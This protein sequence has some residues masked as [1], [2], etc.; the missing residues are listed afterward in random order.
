[1][2]IDDDPN[3]LYEY[4][5]LKDASSTIRL[6]HIQAQHI[7][8]G[9]LPGVPRCSLRQC[10]LANKPKYTAL[11]YA[12]GDANDTKP[13][14]LDGRRKEVT[15]SLWQ[16]L[17]Q[18]ARD[19]RDE[20]IEIQAYWIDAL[21][22]NQEDDVE[23]SDQVAM[24]GQIYKKASKLVVWLGA[25][26]HDSHHAFDFLRFLANDHSDGAVIRQICA[27]KNETITALVSLLER[28]WWRR[29]WVQQ[30]VALTDFSKTEMVCGK[31][32]M[33]WR[34]VTIA[35]YE[36]DSF[37]LHRS[38]EKWHLGAW[39]RKDPST[40]GKEY[41]LLT[42]LWWCWLRMRQTCRNSISLNSVSSEGKLTL[43]NRLTVNAM[44]PHHRLEASNPVDYVYSLVS[45]CSDLDL[46][47]WRPDYSKPK[48]HLY[49]QVAEYLLDTRGPFTLALCSCTLS[50]SQCLPTW[51][52][53][54]STRLSSQLLSQPPSDKSRLSNAFSSQTKFFYEIH[55]QRLLLKATKLDTLRRISEFHQR[56]PDLPYSK[57]GVE[58]MARNWLLAYVKFLDSMEPVSKQS[59]ADAWWRLPICNQ[60]PRFSHERKDK[61][62]G[63]YFDDLLEHAR[64]GFIGDLNMDMIGYQDLMS[65][66]TPGRAP[67][68][69]ARHAVG[70]GSVGIR[71]GDEIFVLLGSEVPLILRPTD[72]DTYYL[73]GEAYV[74]GLEHKRFV[75]NNVQLQKI[76]VI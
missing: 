33:T 7:A 56:L 30:E 71:P 47:E 20:R 18:I 61:K 55:D 65:N 10:L 14:L 50:E 42:N 63:Q 37:L 57:A 9:D 13:I 2:P 15:R 45:I 66:L 58:K 60:R 8:L 12:W 5:L 76:A 72:Q 17:S 3:T 44:E 64:R 4:E 68:I 24:M 51:V 16:F 28:S 26:S 74:Y 49:F 21:S 36:I 70:L 34:K 52:P 35:H 19:Q 23:K 11:S 62:W 22:I 40:P 38:A 73:I 25:A 32:R 48:E 39:D 53:D 59:L 67:F 41:E 1:M 27:K 29:L 54:L 6:V 31:S 75:T 69:T 46:V 43:A